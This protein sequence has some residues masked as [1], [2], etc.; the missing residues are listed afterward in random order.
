[1]HPG[2]WEK[3]QLSGKLHWPH[4]VK[5]KDK[6]RLKIFSLQKQTK[7]RQRISET[8]TKFL[9]SP[10]LN[11]NVPVRTAVLFLPICILSMNDACPQRLG[12]AAA[13]SGSPHR[14]HWR[15]Q[16]GGGKRRPWAGNYLQTL[17]AESSGDHRPPAED[18]DSVSSRGVGGGWRAGT[19][20]RCC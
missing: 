1:M 14:W 10:M 5:F 3:Q 8:K 6:A 12:G 20:R 13:V 7:T 17:S 18:G 16:G 4:V 2:S 19:A 9:Y 11:G 15:W